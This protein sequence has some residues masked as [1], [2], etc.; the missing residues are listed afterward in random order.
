MEQTRSDVCIIEHLTCVGCCGKDFTSREE[1]E[2]A[3][4]KNTKDFIAINNKIKFMKR[5]DNEFLHDSGICR[6]IIYTNEDED[7]VMCPLHPCFNDTKEVK[8]IRKG[9]CEIEYLCK[10]AYVFN[11]FSEEKKKIFRKFILGK[12]L[13]WLEFSVGMNEGTFLEEFEL[14]NY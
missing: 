3:V 12:D 2:K 8:D 9:H 11:N 7:D 13:D 6:N 10:T 14:K 4:R 1:I 5:K